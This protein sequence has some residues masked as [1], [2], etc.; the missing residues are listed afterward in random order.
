MWRL[1]CLPG[2]S[3]Q[4]HG[5]ASRHHHVLPLL[6]LLQQQHL[7]QQG[8]IS[9]NGLGDGGLFAGGQSSTGCMPV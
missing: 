1:L 4:W 7:Q 2:L 9:L 8:Q 3:R 5:H 6:L